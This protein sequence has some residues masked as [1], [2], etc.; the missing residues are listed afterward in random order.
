MIIGI[1]TW[2]CSWQDNEIVYVFR[3]T[4]NLESKCIEAVDGLADVGAKSSKKTAS[5]F[6]FF[7]SSKRKDEMKKKRK[8]FDEGEPIFAARN[9][10]QKERPKTRVQN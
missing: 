10:G 7:P 1:R 8:Q 5:A 2:L 6:E 9:E 4:N 3:M